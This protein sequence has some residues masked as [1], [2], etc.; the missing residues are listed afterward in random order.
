MSKEVLSIN[1]SYFKTEDQ[2]IITKLGG[3]FYVFIH[4][5]VHF[6]SSMSRLRIVTPHLMIVL[7][8][9]H[10]HLPIFTG[11]LIEHHCN[12]S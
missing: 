5:L 6:L 3:L 8:V 11:R 10:V 7:V 4:P 2:K 9:D 1:I 12:L